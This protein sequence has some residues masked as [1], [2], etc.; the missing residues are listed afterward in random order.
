MPEEM[1]NI[2]VDGFLSFIKTPE[3]KIA[4]E[5]IYGVD[6]MKRSS[7]MDY[8]SVREMLKELGRN[9]ADLMKK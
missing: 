9:A 8:D 3:G 2:I 5:K 6:D 4:F 1:K 7:D